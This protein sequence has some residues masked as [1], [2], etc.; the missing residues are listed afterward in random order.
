MTAKY[1]LDACALL[2][3]L[4]D[5]TGADIVADTIKAANVDKANLIMH[6]VNLLE[7]YYDVYRSIGK[8]RADEVV[9][10]VKSQPITIISDISD[11][12][13][14]EAGRLKASY[15]IS[16]AD[17][18]ALAGTSVVGGILL[19]ADHHEMDKV[20]QSEPNIKFQWIR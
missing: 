2:A 3:L 14:E 18:V 4:R 7:V 10:K 9:S 1:V 19:T 17:A 11:A 5:E 15:K 13:F 8:A 20:E 16:L 6:K 12:L